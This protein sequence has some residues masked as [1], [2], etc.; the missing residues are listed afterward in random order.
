MSI[1]ELLVDPTPNSPN[2][3]CKNLLSTNFI[4][5][6]SFQ[7]MTIKENREV[8]EIKYRYTET[9]IKLMN[10]NNNKVM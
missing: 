10:S 8:K 1:R 3:T 5:L 4:V 7:V 6:D 2:K 9:L